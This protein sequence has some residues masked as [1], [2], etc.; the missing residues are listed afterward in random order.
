MTEITL[1]Q[2]ALSTAHLARHEMQDGDYALLF[3]ALLLLEIRRR[4]AI[5][6]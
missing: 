3:F 1:S 4:K 6:N 2:P 5:S